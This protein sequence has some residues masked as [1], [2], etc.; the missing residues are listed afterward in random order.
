MVHL[1][2]GCYPTAGS[3]CGVSVANQGNNGGAAYVSSPYC[4]GGGGGAGSAGGAGLG[5]AK[6]I[7]I[8]L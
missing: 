6:Y 2:G 1:G 8:Y 7:F 3:Q 4:G 5:N